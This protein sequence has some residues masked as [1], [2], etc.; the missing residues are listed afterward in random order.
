MK[1]ASQSHV[2]VVATRVLFPSAREP[3]DSYLGG[4]VPAGR[5][6]Q[7][8]RMDRLSGLSLCA[9]DQVLLLPEARARLHPDATGVLIGTEY[10]CHKTDEAF[11]R[12][13]LAGEPSPR[14]F[15]YTLPSSPVGEV[16]IHHRLLG[17]GFSIVSGRTAGLEALLAARLLLDQGQASACLV[18]SCEV[19]APALPRYPD[20]SELCD[21]A[22]AVLLAAGTREGE[23]VL[24]DACS[25]YCADA[26]AAALSQTVMELA[27]RNPFDNQLAPLLICDQETHALLPAELKQAK[28]YKTPRCGAAAAL[29]V[30]SALPS[31]AEAAGANQ[32]VV[33]SADKSGQ[34]VAV[35]WARMRSATSRTAPQPPGRAVT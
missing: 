34:A 14:L 28:M 7:L 22:V 32:W 4:T 2:A 27:G 11:F 21:A 10:G 26:P 3:L 24:A 30:L 20:D 12:G 1:N 23:P 25:V 5:S 33:L 31:Y 19:A 16:S 8:G 9:A 15:A 29:A 17:P 13:V 6:G 18:L 35:L